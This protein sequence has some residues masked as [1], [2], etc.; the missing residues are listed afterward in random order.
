[1]VA[2]PLYVVEF[3]HWSSIGKALTF[4]RRTQEGR[5]K[6]F[7][8]A[9]EITE[10]IYELFRPDYGLYYVQDLYNHLHRLFK[11]SKDSHL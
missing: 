3:I 6:I 1:M 11:K 2:S 9:K 10:E 4:H 8:E 7:T 5:D